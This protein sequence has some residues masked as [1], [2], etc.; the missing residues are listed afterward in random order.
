VSEHAAA[1]ASSKGIE[2]IVVTAQMELAELQFRAGLLR[3]S[4]SDFEKAIDYAAAI[5]PAKANAVYSAAIISEELGENDRAE[6][7]YERFYREFL[8]ADSVARTARMNSRYLVVP[9]KLADLAARASRPGESAR[10][11][12]DAERLYTGLIA[13]ETDP[14]L[15]K[16]ARFNLLAVYLQQKSWDQGL[17]LARGL[18]ELYP[19]PQD[20][21]SA[22]FVEARIQESGLGRPQEAR[23]TYLSIAERYPRERE[24]AAAL[25][26]AAGI[27]RRAGRLDAARA[28][29]ERVAG[30]F[31]D[32]VSE[33]VEAAWQL[34]E[35]DER[36]GRWEEASLRYKAIYADYPETLQGFEAPLRGARAYG[37]KGETDAAAAAY[38]RALEHYERLAGEQRAPSTRIMAEE[39]VVR[40][41]AE[42]TRWRE[43]AERLVRLPDRY[44]DYT[45]FRQN[46]LRAAS[47]HEREL[48]DPEGAAR[49]LETCVAKYPGTELARAAEKE[50]SRLRGGGK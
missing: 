31:R 50:L 30:S 13:A 24:A 28:L 15:L 44:P 7:F 10:W 35:M 43:A 39:Y 5:P 41:L 46:Y 6:H 37:T 12:G 34:A 47:I 27:D 48:A 42:R 16:E 29:Y 25:L 33:A 17:A 8:P 14:G 40:T 49:L 20:V 36:A 2:E 22:L 21:S 9:I 19:L 26:S 3:E 11:Y 32:R 45:P 1:A 38:E 18:R 4:R 23:A